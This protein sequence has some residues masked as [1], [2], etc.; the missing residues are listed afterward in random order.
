MPASEIPLFN[1]AEPLRDREVSEVGDRMAGGAG[2]IRGDVGR[3]HEKLEAL[4][5]RK[6]EIDRSPVLVADRI[7]FHR[8]P[9]ERTQEEPRVF[10]HAVCI[11]EIYRDQAR[12]NSVGRSEPVLLGGPICPRGRVGVGLVPALGEERREGERPPLVCWASP[13]IDSR[14]TSSVPERSDPA[15]VRGRTPTR[16]G[17]SGSDHMFRR[18]RADRAGRSLAAERNLGRE[19]CQ[20][21]RWARRP[22]GP[23][24]WAARCQQ[25][26]EAAQASSSATLLTDKRA[27]VRPASSKWSR[28]PLRG[29][30]YP[31]A[32]IGSSGRVTGGTRTGISRT[33]LRYTVTT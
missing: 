9:R 28:T 17:K 18:F 30:S 8:S 24:P 2:R 25:E 10:G 5:E 20:V 22:S 1:Q 33:G 26:R 11:K 13:K 7:G 32:N 21:Y 14:I 3:D 31:C 16:A 6:I 15:A 27:M 4:I 23:P 29:T 12:E 19:C